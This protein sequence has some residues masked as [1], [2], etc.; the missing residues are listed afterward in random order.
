MTKGK[1]SRTY[2]RAPLRLWTKAKFL[3]FK[4]NREVQ[5]PNY[6]ILK[7]QGL[8]DPKSTH[9]YLGKRVVFVYKADVKRKD[10]KFR[11]IW[12]RI[13]RRHGSNGAV[14]ARFKPNLP[15]RS[16]GS[17]LRVMLYPQHD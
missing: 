6:S 5:H 12:G 8:N 9:H 15:P 1:T 11:T 14:L 13:S 17:T 4:R 10:S 2:Q 3:G 7:I 16:I